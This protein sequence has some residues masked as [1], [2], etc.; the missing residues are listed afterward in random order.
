MIAFSGEYRE[1]VPHSRLV[2]T[3]AFEPEAAGPMGAP[4]LVTVTLEEQEGRTHLA[5]RELYPSKQ[6]LDGVL[7]TGM[8]KGLRATMDQLDELVAELRRRE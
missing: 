2:Y 6:V 3:H 4:A 5:A 1:V 7:A 8:E